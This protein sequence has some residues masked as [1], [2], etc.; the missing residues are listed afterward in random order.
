MYFWESNTWMFVH[1]HKYTCICMYIY[2]SYVHVSVCMHVWCMHVYTYECIWKNSIYMFV[3]IHVYTYIY[4][5]THAHKCIRMYICMETHTKTHA[6]THK[7]AYTHTRAHTS[8]HIHTH[9][10]ICKH[11]NQPILPPPQHTLAYL[12]SPFPF[13]DLLGV[14][15]K[16]DGR[17]GGGWS[18]EEIQGKRGKRRRQREKRTEQQDV[19][20]WEGGTLIHIRKYI[21]TYA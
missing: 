21:C 4:I 15:K 14:L 3:H 7:H 8:T 16:G 11:N 18:G 20:V 13:F 5:H 1:I 6:Y 19:C 17:E 2:L 12:D 9:V 10:S